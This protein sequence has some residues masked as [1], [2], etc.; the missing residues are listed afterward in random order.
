MITKI[1]TIY[2]CKCDDC[3]C[4]YTETS[5]INTKL[6]LSCRI[7]KCNFKDIYIYND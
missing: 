3:G 4:R 1:E 7:K 5:S 2:H 6:C